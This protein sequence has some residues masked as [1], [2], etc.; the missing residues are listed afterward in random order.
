MTALSTVGVCIA[1]TSFGAESARKTRNVFLIVSDGLRWQEVFT[2]AEAALMTKEAGGVRETN[3]LRKE[4]WRDT[5][6][7]RREALLPFF[8]SEIAR[9]GQ[10]FGNQTKGNIVKVANGKNFSYPGYNE[11]LT[12]SGDPRIDSNS[13][14][15][16][17]NV[18]VFEW[19]NGKPSLRGKVAVL[20]TW[21]VFPYIFNIER[22]RLPI[23]PGDE[24]AFEKE[25]IQSPEAVIE[26]MRDTTP[27]WE[28]VTFDSHLIHTATDYVKRKRPGLMFVGFGETD[29]WAHS[30]R[31][32]LYLRAARHMD[33]YVRRLWELAQS[34]PQY[35]GTTTFII[36]A[37]HGRGSGLEE[38]KSHSEKIPSSEADWIAVIGPDT[39]PLGERTGGESQTISQIAATIGALF[40]E[41]YPAAFPGKGGPIRDVLGGKP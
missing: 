8:W 30:G 11:M 10:L 23:W 25:R 24:P 41:D 35:R 17:P 28:D 5:P 31:Y 36:L 27:V 21:D 3:S 32:D 22:S 26:F 4:F 13:K 9:H 15:P 34:L 19:L 40:G 39:P 2:G 16:N 29:E 14:K 7:A 6:E 20:G 37:D 18:T 38:W 33:G 1:V 12:G